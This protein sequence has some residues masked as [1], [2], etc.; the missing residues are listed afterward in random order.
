M[1]IKFKIFLLYIFF[2]VSPY[3]AHTIDKDISEY[4]YL[5]F[6]GESIEKIKTDYVEHV[7]NKAI[8]ESAI[9]I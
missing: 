1:K 9:K 2:L 8:V 3:I 6:L 7:D 5:K 4:D